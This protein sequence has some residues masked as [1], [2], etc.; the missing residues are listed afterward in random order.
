MSYNNQ[1]WKGES[2]RHREAKLGSLRKENTT[3]QQK[4]L[5]ADMDMCINIDSPT[6]VSKC[7]KFVRENFNKLNRSQKLDVIRK[8]NKEALNA[9]KKMKEAKTLKE[10]RMWFKMADKYRKLY[11]SDAILGCVE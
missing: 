5:K 3:Q 10:R 8:I 6:T 1:G 9:S 7:D 11:R 4:D 2:Q